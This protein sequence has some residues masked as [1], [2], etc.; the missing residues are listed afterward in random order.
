MQ[1]EYERYL[2]LGG[3]RS[4]YFEYILM[5]YQDRR[6]VDERNRKEYLLV[7]KDYLE[8]LLEDIQAK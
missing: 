1:E 3:E 5:E 8:L 7:I 4:P 2:N 6:F